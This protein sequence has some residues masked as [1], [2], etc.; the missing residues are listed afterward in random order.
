[1][2]KRKPFTGDMSSIE[3]TFESAQDRLVLQSSDMSLETVASMYAKGAIDASPSYQ[4]RERW[5]P[6]KQSALIESFLLNIPI[7]PIFLAEESFGR[8]SIIDGKQ[9]VTAIAKFMQNDLL[10]EGLEEFQSINGA[11]FSDLPASLRNALQIRPWVRVVT[12]LRQS[13][14]ELKYEVFERLNT[15]GEALCPQEI[16]NSAFRGPLNDTLIK[17]SSN[18]FFRK[19]LKIKENTEPAYLQMLD[20]EYV[21][22]FLMLKTEWRNFSGDFRKSMDHFMMKHRAAPKRSLDAFS[23][24]FNEAIARCEALWGENCFK[25]FASN[26]FRNQFMTGIYDAQMVAVSILKDAEF[27][28]CRKNERRIRASTEALFRAGSDFEK[29]VRVGT[30]TKSSVIGRIETMLSVLKNS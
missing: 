8:Y 30:N 21:L 19:Q 6:E 20:V 16:R 12:L 17:L 23:K 14:P 3:K 10:L 2:S 7:P 15:G 27:E 24:D 22:R 1:M 29:W 28:A 18:P 26:E 13:D 4:R 9:R 5:H 25:R 11:K